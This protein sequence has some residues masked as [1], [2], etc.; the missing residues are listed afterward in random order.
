MPEIYR[1]LHGS[2]TCD[3]CHKT[4]CKVLF[5]RN[6]FTVA[7]C[8]QDCQ[9]ADWARHKTLCLPVMVKDFGEKGRGLVASRDFNVGDLILDDTSVISEFDRWNL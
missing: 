9:K 6:C 2:T 8:H 3:Y 7:Y 4:G 1:E 5:C